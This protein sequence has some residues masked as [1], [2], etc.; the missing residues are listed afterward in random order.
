MVAKSCVKCR[1]F[2]LV[3]CVHICVHASD[4]RL[5]SPAFLCSLSLRFW[6]VWSRK[7]A[8][9][10][11]PV[12]IPWVLLLQVGHFA[13]PALMWVFRIWTP[14]LTPGQQKLYPRKYLPRCRLLLRVLTVCKKWKVLLGSQQDIFSS[15]CWQIKSIGNVSESPKCDYSLITLPKTRL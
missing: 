9:P 14:D 4:Q 6:F 5:M 8:Y 11:V 1:V 10:G 3:M 13:R 12:S 2:F 15:L 7:Q